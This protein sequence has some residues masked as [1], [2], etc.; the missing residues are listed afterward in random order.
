MS[1]FIHYIYVLNFLFSILVGK[2]LQIN[3]IEI[4]DQCNFFALQSFHSS[5]QST[6]GV[7][8]QTQN[9]FLFSY[10]VTIEY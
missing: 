2:T 7:P 9:L 8:N 4:T 1:V 6:P 10:I 5:Q 3:S